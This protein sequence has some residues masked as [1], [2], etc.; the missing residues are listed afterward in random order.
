MGLIIREMTSADRPAIER[1]L[2]EC[3][4]FSAEECKVA[5]ELVDDWLGS[6]DAFY[7]HFAA[8]LG[9]TP[10][11]YVCIGRTPMTQSTW[12]LYWICVSP[13]FQRR[14][15]ARR[16]HEFAEEFIRSRAGKRVVVETSG[17]TDNSGSREF[18]RAIGY[19]VAGEI[20]DYYRPGDS[21]LF[22][23]KEL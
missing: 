22:Y 8:L 1:M 4:A 14:G 18:Y 16:L 3:G 2:A 23:W 19:R 7:L 10:A 17:R 12:H 21:C 5:L 20:P 13:A 9:E 11:G 15:V 6:G